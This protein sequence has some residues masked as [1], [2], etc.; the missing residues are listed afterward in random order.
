MK[1]E[2]R[3]V[4]VVTVFLKNGRGQQWVRRDHGEGPCR[5]CFASR[6]MNQNKYSKEG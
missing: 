1:L 3:K 6:E 2:V 5:L 4:H